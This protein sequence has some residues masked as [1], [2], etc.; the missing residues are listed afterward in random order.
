MTD[1]KRIILHWTAGGYTPNTTDKRHYHF[2]IDGDGN[3][4]SG[5]QP[6][7]ANERITQ[8]NNGDTYAAHTRGLNTGSIGVAIAAMRRAKERPFD[9]GP[10]P[11]KQRQVDALVALVARLAKQYE[12]SVAR[13]TILTHAEV[14]STLGVSQRNKWDI[15]W[16][17][18]MA[19]PRPA[20]EVG[21]ILRNLIAKQMEAYDIPPA[22]KDRQPQSFWA[23]I[24]E[25]F[26]S[27]FG[28]RDK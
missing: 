11:I 22:R 17:P 13:D 8:P 7:E 4:H 6:V 10:A 2:I 28:G 23:F 26:L 27:I 24:V 19:T 3:V 20:I 5:D 12:I 15:M 25:I 21:D 14:Q 9:P 16:L 18:G 1:L